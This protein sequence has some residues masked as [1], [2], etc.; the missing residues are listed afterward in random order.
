MTNNVTGTS[1]P[2][3]ADDTSARDADSGNVPATHNPTPNSRGP[4]R[5]GASKVHTWT[6]TIVAVIAL[7]LSAISLAQNMI[8]PGI[9]IT[10][11]NQIRVAQGSG[12]DGKLKVYIQPSMVIAR[13]SDRTVVVTSFTLSF[14]RVDGLQPEPYIY[15][16]EFGQLTW[17]PENELFDYQR[18]GDPAPIVV[19]QDKPQNPLLTFLADHYLMAPGVWRGELTGVEPNGDRIVQSF[20]VDMT[21]QAAEWLRLKNGAQFRSFRNDLARQDA[22]TCYEPGPVSDE[23]Q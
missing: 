20:C 21:P 9:N 1:T 2:L 5:R 18:I 4:T 6:T 12:P 17:V 14:H 22:N 10:M 13:K 23:V 19:T 8:P 3:D 11:P 7:A 16:N 15:W